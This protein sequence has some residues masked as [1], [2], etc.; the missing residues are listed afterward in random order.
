MKGLT[1]NFYPIGLGMLLKRCGTCVLRNVTTLTKLDISLF[2]VAISPSHQL[3][4]V[5]E[6]QSRTLLDVPTDIQVF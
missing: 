2:L 4:Y 6:S 1:E 3:I 5:K